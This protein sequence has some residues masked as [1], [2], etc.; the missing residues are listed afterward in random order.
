MSGRSGSWVRRLLVLT[1]FVLIAGPATLVYATD[2]LPPPVVQTLNE[3]TRTDPQTALLFTGA[4]VG[5]IGLLSLWVWRAESRSEQLAD[6]DTEEPDRG[7]AIA[8]E[9]LTEAFERRRTGAGVSAVRDDGPLSEALHDVLIDV[10]TH[11]RGTCEAAEQYIEEGDWTA[12]RYAAAFVTTS[13]A[14]NYPLYFRLFAWLYPGEAYEYRAKRALREVETVC[15]MELSGYEAPDRST[16]WR[17]RL[18]SVYRNK[19]DDE[20]AHADR[21][22][23]RSIGS[24]GGGD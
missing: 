11:K 14:I 9:Y 23:S 3:F 19:G 7:G 1:A 6:R 21:S 16:G 2:L 15:E 12:D 8:G 10:C 17:G 18:H 24:N 4:A 22:D 5:I 13:D 20:S